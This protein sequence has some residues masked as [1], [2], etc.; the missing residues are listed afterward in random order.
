MIR[1]GSVLLVLWMAMFARADE[2]WMSLYIQDQKIGYARSLTKDQGYGGA[3]GSMSDSLTVMQ[4]GMLGT[5]LEMRITSQSWFDEKGNPVRMVFVTESAGRTSTVTARFSGGKIET[6][7]TLAGRTTRLTIAIP[8]G[9]RVVD[10]PVAQLVS[11]GL[12]AVGTQATVL[13]FDSN[14]VSLIE[15]RVEFKGPVTVDVKGEKVA[16]HQVDVHDPRA[17][18]TV[19]LCEKGELVKVRG[20]L[21]LFMY[22]E[23]KEVAM[24]GLGESFA[25]IAG[26]SALRP[27][28]PL[29]NPRTA[30]NITFAIDRADFARAEN[31]AHQTATRTETGWTIKVHPVDP[32]QLPSVRIPIAAAAKPEWI[33]P[34]VRVPA[35]SPRFRRLAQ[36]VLRGETNVLRAAE[37]VR[38]YVHREIR[39][40]AGIGVMRDADEILDTKEGVCRDHAVLMAAIL[41]SARIPTRL[42]SGIVYDS[43][44][45]FY[46]AW[47]E[48]WSGHQWVGFD[49]TRFSSRLTAAHVIVSQGTVSEAMTG[50]LIDGAVIRVQE[51]QG[52]VKIEE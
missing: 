22:P 29:R 44:R 3:P 43:G 36:D 5:S 17:P 50:F 46:H 51:E 52:S 45:F 13:V 28:R 14:T 31:G 39:A 41:R 9:R 49:S 16:A 21:G 8:E 30:T 19:Y 25:D 10:D 23:P 24:S 27:D 20:P 35:G 15:T 38:A 47:V 6:E 48:V 33:K 1:I 42:V 12:P 18:T 32:E 26:M 11:G 40:N 7:S 4:A 34:D 37:L 2:V